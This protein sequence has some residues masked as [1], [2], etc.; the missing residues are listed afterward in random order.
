MQEEINALKSEL[1]V[2]RENHPN[3]KSM[4]PGF[5]PRVKNL[6]EHLSAREI[7]D[8]LEIN[9]LN[10]RRRLARQESKKAPSQSAFVKLATSTPTTAAQ[11]MVLKSPS[12]TR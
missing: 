8:A 7:A 4:P 5:W 6:T 12:L 2:H 3:K 10:L 1:T 11:K 9:L